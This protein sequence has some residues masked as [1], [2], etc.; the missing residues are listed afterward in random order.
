MVDTEYGG[1]RVNGAN[2]NIWDTFWTIAAAI[3]GL[4]LPGAILLLLI[5]YFVVFLRWI[6]RDSSLAEA[7]Q[8]TKPARR[9]WL[10]IIAG[11]GIALFILNLPL[12]SIELIRYVLYVAAAVCVVSIF[13]RPL[14]EATRL[15]YWRFW[16]AAGALILL[17]DGLL[18]AYCRS[19]GDAAGL[20]S[21]LPF[22]ELVLVGVGG[23]VFSRLAV[24]RRD[25]LPKV[26]AR[27][28]LC[29]L[30]LVVIEHASLQVSYFVSFRCHDFAG[31]EQLVE[32]SFLPVS[33]SMR[34]MVKTSAPHSIGTP[35]EEKVLKARPDFEEDLARV[36]AFFLGVAGFNAIFVT[37]SRHFGVR[38]A[39]RIPPLVRASAGTL[40]SVPEIPE[41]VRRTVFFPNRRYRQGHSAQ[42]FFF[43]VLGNLFVSAITTYSTAR[44]GLPQFLFSFLAYSGMLLPPIVLGCRNG[45]RLAA[46]RARSSL[47]GVRIL[48]HD[49]RYRPT[50]VKVRKPTLL[51]RLHHRIT[52]AWIRHAVDK[53]GRRYSLLFAV[54][55]GEEFPADLYQLRAGALNESLT[56]RQAYVAIPIEAAVVPPTLRD[57]AGG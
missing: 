35:K 9:L 54:C 30:S 12:G 27:L 4:G 28:A 31:A 3:S 49:P 24:E 25:S 17:F 44:G 34:E 46:Y 5:G 40:A 18:W 43:A 10:K 21:F 1:T 26:V 2:E 55:P 8:A 39:K 33:R 41:P 13:S 20:E 23:F 36:L 38:D 11:T 22:T 32:N 16:S 52:G 53:D 57:A 47:H 6:C 56:G 15:W 42:L 14:R 37:S 29:G 19:G 45:F 48:M 7:W 51:Q 50:R